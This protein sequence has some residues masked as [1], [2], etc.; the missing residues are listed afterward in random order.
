MFWTLL[1]GASFTDRLLE[2]DRKLA[3]ELMRLMLG[4]QLFTFVTGRM[5]KQPH[6]E[7][8]AMAGTNNEA[9]RTLRGAANARKTGRTSKSVQGATRRAGYREG[10]GI[11]PRASS[12]VHAFPAWTATTGYADFQM[13]GLKFSRSRA[14]V[15]RMLVRV[16]PAAPTPSTSNHGRRNCILFFPIVCTEGSCLGS[17]TLPQYLAEMPDLTG[18]AMST[19]AIHPLSTAPLQHDMT[20]LEIA[21]CLLLKNEEIPTLP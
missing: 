17:R 11:S 12:G 1:A 2:T 14:R 5:V 18:I 13:N 20:P 4:K 15:P 7:T 3:N 9:E 16:C 8:F 6:G 19:S 10:A 21:E